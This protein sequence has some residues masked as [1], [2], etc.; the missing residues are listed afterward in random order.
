MS[1]LIKFYK[2]TKDFVVGCYLCYIQ[3]EGN[4][5]ATITSTA[6]KAILGSLVVS[7]A[8]GWDRAFKGDSRTPATSVNT[9]SS[10][11]AAGH[12]SAANKNHKDLALA[13][14]VQV[15]GLLQ[16]PSQLR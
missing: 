6:F 9:G 11:A 12:T 3:E 1:E 16:I 7:R 2:V 13:R 15:R 8:F 4:R 10:I 14:V 5:I